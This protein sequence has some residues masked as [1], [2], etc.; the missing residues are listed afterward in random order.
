MTLVIAQRLGNKLT[1]SSDSRLSF[2]GQGYFDKGIKIFKVPFRLKG[3]AKSI[4]VVIAP[5]DGDF[6][7]AGVRGRTELE[8][9]L[10]RLMPPVMIGVGNPSLRAAL[11]VLPAVTNGI[12]EMRT[13]TGTLGEGVGSLRS[14]LVEGI[15]LWESKNEVDSRS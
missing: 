1:F 14:L 12:C 7:A 2:D 4:E 15:R 13:F 9:L 3:P 6:L 10:E 11:E 8:V 5:P